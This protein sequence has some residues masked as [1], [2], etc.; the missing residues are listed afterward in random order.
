MAG[1]TR[2]SLWVAGV[3]AFGGLI[4]A[5]KVETFRPVA[6]GAIL[7]G[8]FIFVFVTIP[9]FICAGFRMVKGAFKRKTNLGI[10]PTS[11]ESGIPEDEIEHPHCYFVRGPFLTYRH[12]SGE[13]RRQTYQALQGQLKRNR[14]R[15][16]AKKIKL[17]FDFHN[18]SLGDQIEKEWKALTDTLIGLRSKVM[19]RITGT[20]DNDTNQRKTSGGSQASVTSEDVKL[21]QRSPRGIETNIVPFCFASKGVSV[22]LFPSF[23]LIELDDDIKALPFYHLKLHS[24]ADSYVGNA[25][26]DAEVTG[27]T[28]KY[29]NVSGANAGEPDKRR[30]DNVRLDIYR[31]EALEFVYGDQEIGLRFSFSKK[32]SVRPVAN[33]YRSLYLSLL[34]EAHNMEMQGKADEETA[35]PQEEKECSTHEAL[36]LH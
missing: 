7:I 33:A 9:S 26:R 19:S 5:A 1:L 8:L 24:S 30:N 3:L 17:N 18:T 14:S 11:T 15:L 29:V 20:T 35:T 6:A 4:V 22:F 13:E 28:W 25:P 31:C 16:F 23:A 2:K 10:R 21:V 34:L 12:V 32:G 27:R 36:L